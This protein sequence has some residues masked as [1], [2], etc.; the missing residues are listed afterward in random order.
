MGGSGPSGGLAS[1][2]EPGGSL[3]PAVPVRGTREAVRCASLWEVPGS[4]GEVVMGVQL[5]RRHPEPL[6]AL[7][8]A[9][10]PL[11]MRKVAGSFSK[12]PPAPRGHSRV[13]D[14]RDPD[15]RPYRPL[16]GS[17]LRGPGP[18]RKRALVP[19]SF[20]IPQSALLSLSLCVR[21]CLCSFLSSPADSSD[22]VTGSGSHSSL[23]LP[24]PGPISQGPCASGLS[25]LCSPPAPPPFGPPLTPLK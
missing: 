12:L 10:W 19:P 24:V 18:V 8:P 1:R 25:P 14:S 16:G 6:S 2:A 11:G 21:L 23:S 3:S 15:L 9:Q 17:A 20:S 7:H 22:G 4:G 13:S 5:G